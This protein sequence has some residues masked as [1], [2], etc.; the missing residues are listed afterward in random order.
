VR[1][2]KFLAFE[3]KTGGD[4]FTASAGQAAACSGFPREPE[5]LNSMIAT[6]RKPACGFRNP[7]NFKI[8]VYFH[9]GG[10]AVHPARV[11]H[12]KAG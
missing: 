11:T 6:V 9:C 7:D 5:G 3:A 1:V 2:G 12:S 8:A 10:L 4:G